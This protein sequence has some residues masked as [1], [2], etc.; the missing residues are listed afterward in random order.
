MSMSLHSVPNGD[1]RMRETN[2]GKRFETF[3]SSACGVLLCY[4]IQRLNYTQNRRSSQASFVKTILDLYFSLGKTTTSLAKVSGQ[5]KSFAR[6]F[7]RLPVQDN[8]SL[9]KAK[10]P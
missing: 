6:T 1:Q 9:A 5:E 4:Y 2:K 8:S 3:L 7:A 10:N